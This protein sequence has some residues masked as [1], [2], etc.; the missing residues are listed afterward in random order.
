[1]RDS[2]V[3][4]FACFTSFLLILSCRNTALQTLREAIDSS[5]F[6]AVDC[7]GSRTRLASASHAPLA[8]GGHTRLLAR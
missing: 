3:T 1:M 8:Y 4:V 6:R 2:V 7:T 5:A